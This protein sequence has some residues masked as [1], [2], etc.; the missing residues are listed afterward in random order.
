MDTVNAGL[1][2]TLGIIAG[3]LLGSFAL[4]MKRIREWKW[5]NVWTMYSVW[6]LIILPW[7]LAWYTVPR[8]SEVFTSAPPRTILMVLLFGAG[9]GV[10]NVGF[11]VG[12]R[13][14]GMALGMAIV[15]GM[16]NALGAILPIILFHPADL[17]QPAGLAIAV[18]VF[19]MLLGIIVCALAGA[20]K[21]MVLKAEASRDV[22]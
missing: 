10:A 5:E 7:C 21:E 12:L 2:L 20:Q 11:G 14:L 22:S 8:L 16:N 1:G 9:W 15:L 6:A 4:P 3:T 13:L 19:V 17:A 18:A